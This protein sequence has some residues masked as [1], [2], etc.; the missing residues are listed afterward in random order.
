MDVT[1]SIVTA[2]VPAST[3]TG[4]PEKTIEPGRDFLVGDP[5]KARFKL[6]KKIGCGSFGDIYLGINIANGEEV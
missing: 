1:A 4:P 2:A 6:V 5:D 3:V